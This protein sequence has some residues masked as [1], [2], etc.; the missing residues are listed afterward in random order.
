ME[1]NSFD[2]DASECN[3]WKITQ[4]EHGENT[5][6]FNWAPQVTAPLPLEAIS[7]LFERVANNQPHDLLEKLNP[8]GRR[9]ARSQQM[10]SVTKEFFQSRPNGIRPDLVRHDVLGFFSLVLSYAKNARAMFE[11]ESPKELTT[12]MPR[13][14]FNAMFKL[15]RDRVPG[16]LYEVVKVLGCY[17]NNGGGNFAYVFVIKSMNA[18]ILI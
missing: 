8:Q 2:I 1:P 12:I 11:D 4:P 14:H 17:K 6:E 10:V 18:V 7:Y 5:G 15:V 3:P 9:G 13:T 16:K